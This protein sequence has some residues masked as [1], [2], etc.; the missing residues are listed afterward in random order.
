MATRTTLALLLILSAPCLRGQQPPA[1]DPRAVFER[2]QR[3]LLNQDYARAQAGF[4]EVLRL[5]PR[6][7][8]ALSNLG[9][10]YMR[11][12]KYDLAI[13]TFLQARKWDPQVPG[14]ALNLALA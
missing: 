12:E 2:A 8:A 5:N 3:A 11:T 7:V 9:V 4:Q 6:S 10:V 14:I 13:Q 1:E